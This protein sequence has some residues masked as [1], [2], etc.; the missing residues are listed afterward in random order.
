MEVGLFQLGGEAEVEQD[1]A[2]I[3]VDEH[4]GGLDVAVELASFVQ[5]RD[6]RGK[7][8]QRRPEANE[9]GQRQA[10]IPR[11]TRHLA[12]IG[13]PLAGGGVVRVGYTSVSASSVSGGRPPGVWRS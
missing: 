12:W 8:P 4:V 10:W 11:R 6:P 13:C 1:D 5:G 9:P 7:L 2:S 3:T